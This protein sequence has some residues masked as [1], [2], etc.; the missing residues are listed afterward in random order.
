VQAIPEKGILGAYKRLELPSY[1]EG[2]TTLYYV[3][4]NEGKL[5]IR[6]WES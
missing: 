1:D 5:D 3:K 4:L 6:E 2:F